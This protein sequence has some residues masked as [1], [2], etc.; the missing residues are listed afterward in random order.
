[1]AYKVRIT[2]P[3]KSDAYEYSA[4]ILGRNQSIA[5]AH[6]WL[7]DLF[8][9]L[10]SLSDMPN[11]FAVIPESS[12]LSQEYRS[13]FFHSHRIIF[14]VDEARKEV[15]VH[16]IYHEARRPLNQTDLQG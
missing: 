10:K 3:A 1:M 16:R 13:F 4:F 5:S 12:E 15:I 7:N 6:K 9:E 2:E 11:R 8:D 14:S